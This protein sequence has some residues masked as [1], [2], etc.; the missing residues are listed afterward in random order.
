MNFNILPIHL[1]SFEYLWILQ[2][3]GLKCRCKHC[4]ESEATTQ[5]DSAHFQFVSSSDHLVDFSATTLQS[6]IDTIFHFELITQSWPTLLNVIGW[7]LCLLSDPLGLTQVEK[8]N[9][10]ISL[11]SKLSRGVTRGQGMRQPEDW[12]PVSSH[13]KCGVQDSSHKIIYN[14]L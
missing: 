1:F 6:N 9:K 4:T 2:Q 10:H 11:R 8:V 12:T 5:T 13:P 7:N 3:K 14:Y